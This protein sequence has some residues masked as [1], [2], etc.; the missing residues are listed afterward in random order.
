MAHSFAARR[1]VYALS[2]SLVACGKLAAGGRI[3]GDAS[4]GNDAGGRAAED[5][6]FASSGRTDGEQAAGGHSE[7]V[8]GLAGA[9]AAGARASSGDPGVAGLSSN[10]SASGGACS[11]IGM[12][13]AGAPG[14]VGCYAHE[15]G[16]WRQVACNCELDVVNPL[17]AA[18]MVNVTLSLDGGATPSLTGTPDVEVAFDDP[19][20]SWFSMWSGQANKTGSFAVS[21]DGTSTTVRLGT[22]RVVLDA[23]PL[24]G[25]DRRQGKAKNSGTGQTFTLQATFV[26][27]A[28]A[29]TTN[30][31]TDLPHP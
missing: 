31:C 20:S 27:S 18:S 13:L 24:A 28:L 19:D 29:A 1:L 11:D 5:D 17:T 12:G 23:V 10:T 14:A 7:L 3:A 26:D 25:C 22:S 2:I 6:G 15:S 16:G 21:H 9:S 30:T 4:A 8:S